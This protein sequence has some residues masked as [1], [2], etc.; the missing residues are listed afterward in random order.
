M[1]SIAVNLLEKFVVPL[2]GWGVFLA[3]VLEEVVVP[4]PSAGIL[5]GSGFLFLKGPLTLALLQTLFFTV[6]IPAALGLT[7]GSLVIYALAYKGGKPFLLRYGKW[8]GVGWEDVE[9]VNTKFQS[10]SYDEWSIILAR[11]FP[12]IPSVLIAVFCGV[13]RMPV[14]KYIVLTLI[15]AFFKALFLGVVGW[16]VGALYME[17]AGVIGKVENLVLLV[18]I[19]AFGAFVFYRKRKK[20]VL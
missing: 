1:I 12:I 2:G 15:G 9:E 8:F 13:T 19:L 6:V 5:L 18:I 10:G 7:L 3:E 11:V 17:Y 4:I 14:K 16:Q 20:K